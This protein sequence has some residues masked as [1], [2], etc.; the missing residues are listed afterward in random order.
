MKYLLLALLI[1]S[2]GCTTLTTQKTMPREILAEYVA[3]SFS[4]ARSIKYKSEE[5]EYWQ[6]PLETKELKTGDCEDKAFYLQFLLS[7]HNIPSKV[8]VGYTVPPENPL[9]EWKK[10]IPREK[11][12]PLH[13]WNEV[14]MGGAT[15]IVDPTSGCFR[16]KTMLKT[17]YKWDIT[18][19]KEILTAYAPHIRWYISKAKKAGYKN[20]ARDLEKSFFTTSE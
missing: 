3:K 16:D 8:V 4:E 9:K 11:K 7:K 6:L 1:F 19:E 5:Q 15:Y 17:W 13:V 20:F 18:K 12:T 10:D 2:T 14:E